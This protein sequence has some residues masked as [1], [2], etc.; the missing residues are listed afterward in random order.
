MT[1]EEIIVGKTPLTFAHGRVVDVR[2]EGRVVR[3]EL[4]PHE[5]GRAF[6]HIGVERVVEHAWLR[7]VDSYMWNETTSETSSGKYG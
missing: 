5:V 6:S 1:T 7:C 4:R 2:E 3:I